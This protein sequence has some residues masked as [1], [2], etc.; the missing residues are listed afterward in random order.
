MIILDTNVLAEL[1]RRTPHRGVVSWLD[2]L[3]TGEVATTA[4]TAA[5]L[6]YGLSRLP[7]GRRRRELSEAVSAMLDHDLRDRVEP[8]DAGAAAHYADIVAERER[9]GRP[10][11]L[12]DAQIAAIC[13]ARRAR[14]ATRNGPDVTDVGVELID[15]WGFTPEG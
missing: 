3:S 7:E 14:L 1:T 11:G 13:R 4:V 15:P 8:F 9:R 6:W 2:S 12:A 5:E 10:I